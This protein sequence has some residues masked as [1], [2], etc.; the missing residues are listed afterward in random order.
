MPVAHLGMRRRPA[1]VSRSRGVGLACSLTS[2]NRQPS[3]PDVVHDHIRLRKHQIIAAACVGVS[4]GARH[5]QHAGRTDGREIVGGSSCS[6][7]LSPGGVR[8]R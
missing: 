4:L 6:S 8:P 7:E 1:I 2:C 3:E 5:V